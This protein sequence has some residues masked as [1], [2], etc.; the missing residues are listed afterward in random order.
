MAETLYMRTS[1]KRGWTT[2]YRS[3]AQDKR[4]SL[5]GRGLFL[6]MQSLPEDWKYTVAGLAAKAGTGKDQIRSGL[7]E[8]EKVGYLIK[9]QAHDPSGKFT[10][11]V[12][13]LQDEAPL[14]ENPT[15]VEKTTPPLSENP[16]TGKP[17]TGNP[18]VQNT[19]VQSIDIHTPPISPPGGKRGRR[20]VKNT[21]D[22]KPER[23]E[24]FWAYYRTRVRSEDR[25]AAIR[26]W[27][28]LRP[29]DALIARIGRALETQVAS[30]SWQAGYGKPYASTYLN[31]RRWEDVEGLSDP[32]GEAPC[33]APK[34]YVRTDVIDGQEVDIYE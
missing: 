6:L 15:T 5:K 20:E 1:S 12:F 21:A 32:D 31:R 26:A 34:R 11:N 3:V 29:D 4:L 17:S 25:Q 30:K 13:I 23:F 19:E 2:I 27:D 28:K 24:A 8:L 18:T 33:Q 14:S 9:D 22:W 10:G 7:K 16:S